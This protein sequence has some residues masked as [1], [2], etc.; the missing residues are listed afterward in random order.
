M[1]PP[2][3]CWRQ[4]PCLWLERS[5][6]PG[7]SAGSV[8][9]SLKPPRMWSLMSLRFK[10]WPKNPLAFSRH[11]SMAGSDSLGVVFRKILSCSSTVQDQTEA[12]CSSNL[13][14]ANGI[15]SKKTQSVSSCYRNLQDLPNKKHLY[16]SKSSLFL[17]NWSFPHRIVLILPS[18][19][20]HQR[21][22]CCG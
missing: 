14:V 21:T 2:C 19:D 13:I 16:T 20:L 6:P 5:L 18:A 7:T 10:K 4:C 22:D 3:L 9:T 1:I 12:I 15:S 17:V 8:I 11:F